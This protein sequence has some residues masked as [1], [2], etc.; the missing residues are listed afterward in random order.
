MKRFLVIFSILF[1]LCGCSFGGNT[2]KGAVEDYLNGY[3]AV[4]ETKEDTKANT[5]EKKSKA[6]NTE[7]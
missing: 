2:A 4:D 5:K 1:L 3:I 6:K 7:E